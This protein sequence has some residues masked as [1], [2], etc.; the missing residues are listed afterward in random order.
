MSGLPK[1]H[2]LG[3]VY[4]YGGG[5]TGVVLLGFGI[6]GFAS[7][8]D[9]FS[10]DGKSVAGL[11]SNGAL[12]LISV[13]VGLCLIGCAAVGGN[14]SA[15]ANSVFGGL[16]MLSGLV[17]LAVMRTDLNFLAFRMS[18]VIFSFVVGI[19]LVTCGMYGRV[20]ASLPPD[21]PY[22]RQRHG[23]PTEVQ[24]GEDLATETLL[25]GAMDGNRGTDPRN[26]SGVGHHIQTGAPLPL[27]SGGPVLAGAPDQPRH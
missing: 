8:L 12:S 19:A 15:W 4:R 16:F 24:D 9:F 1:D 23:L 3:K 25:G 18:N 21:N 2:K 13:V 14:A 6:L 26:M 7:R 5:A 17:N 11:S 22:W 20:S 10:T 27:L